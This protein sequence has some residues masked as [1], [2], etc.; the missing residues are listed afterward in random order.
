M[1]TKNAKKLPFEGIQ[2]ESGPQ[3]N[4]ISEQSRLT[5]DEMEIESTGPLGSIFPYSSSIRFILPKKN[6]K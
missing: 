4:P 2:S 1:E 3:D 6:D 5:A